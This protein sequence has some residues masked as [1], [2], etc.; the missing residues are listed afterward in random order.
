VGENSTNLTGMILKTIDSG[1]TWFE[2][3]SGTTNS[4]NA[5]FF[6]DANTGYTIG[7]GGTI[8]KTSDGGTDFIQPPESLPNSFTIYPNPA[9]AKINISNNPKLT[10]ETSVSIFNITGE[11]VMIGKLV[12]QNR[13]EM[14]VSNLPKGLYLVKLQNISRIEIQKLVIR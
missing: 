5:V 3:S 13:I 9:N 6:T 11:E 2:L 4:L 12:N 1:T 14:D 7:W 10:E 8:L